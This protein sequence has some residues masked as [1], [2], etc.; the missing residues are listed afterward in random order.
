MPLTYSAAA[1][2]AAA[3]GAIMCY[4]FTF[5]FTQTLYSLHRKTVITTLDDDFHKCSFYVGLTNLN[6]ASF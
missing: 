6:A 3:C 5:T 1:T 4:T 2:A